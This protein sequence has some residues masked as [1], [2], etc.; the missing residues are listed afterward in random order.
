VLPTWLKDDPGRQFPTSKAIE[1]Y[2]SELSLAAVQK[3]DVRKA[4]MIYPP[5]RQVVQGTTSP[6]RL[7]YK[8]VTQR[9]TGQHH[10]ILVIR[11]IET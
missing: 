9:K 6:G 2:Q 10:V 3:R 1:G 8:Y 7:P 11:P 5:R 4:G